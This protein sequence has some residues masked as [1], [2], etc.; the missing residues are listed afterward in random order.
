MNTPGLMTGAVAEHTLGLLLGL[1]RGLFGHNEAV[2]RGGARP[3]P[4]LALGDSTIGIVGMGAIGQEVAR[5]L[6]AGFGSD[7]LYWSRTRRPAAE[8]ALGMANAELA[9]LFGRADAVLLLLA[10]APETRGIVA[11]RLFDAVRRPIFLVNTAAADLVDPAALRQALD[12]GRVAA[13]AFDGYWDE[14]LPSPAEDRFGLLSCPDSRFVV[15]PHVAAKTT[16]AWPR[17]VDSAV[18]NLL[19][20]FEG[21]HDALS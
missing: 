18:A 9:E 21:D 4:T 5:R 2:K 12:D 8:E 7:L 11:A 3:G 15:T 1:Q 19:R 13:A 20:H 14:P 10:S 16:T 6:R 17:M